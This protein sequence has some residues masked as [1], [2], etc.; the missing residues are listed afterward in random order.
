[1]RTD[2]PTPI[3]HA[4]TLNEKYYNEVHDWP[5][6]GISLREIQELNADQLH[7][8]ERAMRHMLAGMNAG[9]TPS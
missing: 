4:T 3:R 5:F 1:M 7:D 2:P 6:S 9:K 8:L